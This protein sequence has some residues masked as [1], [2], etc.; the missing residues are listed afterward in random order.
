M[1]LTK[2]LTTAITS[3]AKTCYPAECCGLII[4]DEYYPCD[5]IAIDPYNHFEID[6]SEFIKLSKIGEIKAIVH[7][8]PDGAGELSEMD[9][10]QMGLHGVDWVI[11]GVGKDLLTHDFYIDLQIHK[12]KA[13]HT[14]LLGREYVHGVQDCYTLVQDY[15]KRE[16]NIDLP[17]FKRIDDWWEDE[18]HEP[19][20]QNNFAKAGFVVVDDIKPH[21]VILCRVGRTHHINHALIFLGNGKLTSENTPDCVGDCLVLHHP[22]G[23]LS[24]R[25]MYGESWQ[26]RT[27]LVVRHQTLSQTNL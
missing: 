12:A 16:L 2:Q 8:H 19:L 13:H 9:K 6:P 21:D 27:A 3:H 20:Y 17:N 25:E 15:F 23:R 26:R 18:N 5:N 22:H 4:G 7:S 14:P 10:I 11:C 24:V 1:Q